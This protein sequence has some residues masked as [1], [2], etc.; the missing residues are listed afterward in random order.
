MRLLSAI[1]IYP[2]KSLGGISVDRA[3]LSSRGLLYDRRWMLVDAQGLFLTQRTV[4]ELTR[5]L[6]SMRDKVL[7]VSDREGRCPPLEV[8]LVPD[9]NLMESRL[10]EIWED[11]VDAR[12][13]GEEADQWFSEL[14]K[15]KVSLVYMHDESN[16]SVDERY[17]P[18]GQQVGFAD[19]FPFLLLGASSLQDLNQRLEEPVPLDRFRANLVFTG[20]SPYEE[21]GWGDFQIGAISFRGVKP[22]ARC[23]V[24]TTHQQSG[25]RCPEPLKTLATYRKFDGKVLFGQNAICTD[26]DFKDKQ[27][28]VGDTISPCT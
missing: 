16:R 20:G 18:E 17:V 7:A 1:Y 15:K 12:H 24:I 21:E 8:P 11:T 28:R 3:G 6:C 13:C 22:C 2:I 26:P 4:P 14:L 10:V 23:Q 19:G 5:L 25:I 27:V 9:V